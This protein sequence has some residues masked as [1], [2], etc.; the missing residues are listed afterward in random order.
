MADSEILAAKIITQ[1]G[2]SAVSSVYTQL[3]YHVKI[4]PMTET[5]LEGQL[6]SSET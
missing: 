3:W 5:C 4:S 1:I 6:S 2:H